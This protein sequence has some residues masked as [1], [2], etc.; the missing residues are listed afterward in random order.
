MIGNGRQRSA[1]NVEAG[2]FVVGG[3]GGVK[4]LSFGINGKSRSGCAGAQWKMDE[5]ESS[6]KAPLVPIAKAE[7]LPAAPLDTYKKPCVGE[8]AINCGFGAASEANETEIRQRGSAG[9]ESDQ[10]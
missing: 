4:E 8:I 10:C 9:L 1:G 2:D 6:V 7:I 5:P 3:I